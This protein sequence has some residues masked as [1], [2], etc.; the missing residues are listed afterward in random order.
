MFQIQERTCVDWTT[1]GIPTGS[2]QTQGNQPQGRMQV[3][4]QKLC[5]NVTS[6]RRLQRQ[7]HHTGKFGGEL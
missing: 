5:G 1:R 7:A 3:H 6:R 2:L 4:L